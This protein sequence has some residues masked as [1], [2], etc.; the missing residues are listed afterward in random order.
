MLLASLFLLSFDSPI[1][2]PKFHRPL[3]PRSAL[4]VLKRNSVL[5]FPVS[6]DSCANKEACGADLMDVGARVEDKANE[7]WVVGDNRRN[8]SPF[9]VVGGG[10]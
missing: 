9:R 8:K 10:K 4:S 3:K 5:Y 2:G 7:S 1:S 6:W